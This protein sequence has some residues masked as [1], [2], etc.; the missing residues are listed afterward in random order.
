MAIERII[1]EHDQTAAHSDPAALLRGRGNYFSGVRLERNR[2]DRDHSIDD[3]HRDGMSR[4]LRWRA[5]V[6]RERSDPVAAHTST[7]ARVQLD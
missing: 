6:A 4:I 3:E 2:S 7:E 5:V 1:H